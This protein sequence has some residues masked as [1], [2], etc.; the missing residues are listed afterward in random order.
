MLVN[1][2]IR[3]PF[4]NVGSR[5]GSVIAATILAAARHYVH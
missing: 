3:M 2:G 5:V 4:A 1:P